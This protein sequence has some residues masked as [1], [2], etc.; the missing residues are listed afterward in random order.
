MGSATSEIKKIYSQL[1]LWIS[2]QTII[3][4]G[5]APSTSETSEVRC[6]PLAVGRGMKGRDWRLGLWYLHSFEKNTLT[7]VF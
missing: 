1:F 7:S 2:R 4:I 3:R 6:R 5:C